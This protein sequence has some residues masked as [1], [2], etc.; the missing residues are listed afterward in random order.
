MQPHVTV[1]VACREINLRY[2]DRAVALLKLRKNRVVF[3]KSGEFL[4]IYY[5]D[6]S[7]GHGP[8]SVEFVLAQRC[9]EDALYLS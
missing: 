1:F 7:V 5:V 2:V 8:Q 6:T 3:G 4:H 9:C